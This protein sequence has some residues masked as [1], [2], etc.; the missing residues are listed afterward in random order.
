MLEKRA[1]IEQC[2]RGKS[3]IPRIDGRRMQIGGLSEIS[4]EKIAGFEWEEEDR[5][6]KVSLSFSLVSLSLVVS[7]NLPHYNQLSVLKK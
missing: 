4:E 3:N 6:E 5:R 2:G 7:F 1:T